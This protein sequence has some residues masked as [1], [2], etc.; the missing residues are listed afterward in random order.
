MMIATLW[1]E[2]VQG[3]FGI[4]AGALVILGAM[5]AG[6]L[7]PR[8]APAAALVTAALVVINA[9]LAPAYATGPD[10]AEAFRVADQAAQHVARRID[11]RQPRFLAT[12]GVPLG[13]FYNA[14][15]AIYLW[16]Y[17]VVTWDYPAISAAGAEQISPG[18]LVTIMSDGPGQLEQFNV[19]A[20]PHGLRGE[21]VAVE[22]IDTSLGPF[23][24]TFVRTYTA[25]SEPGASPSGPA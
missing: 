8:A 3:V 22:S 18:T 4:A 6:G 7:A 5:A 14:T 19:A 9:W 1:P 12:Q 10:R 15:A 16:G 21:L 23:Y 11:G 25:E 20:A 2:W 24:L 17:T 13:P